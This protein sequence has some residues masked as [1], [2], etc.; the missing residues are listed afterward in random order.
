MQ[1]SMAVDDWGFPVGKAGLGLDDN[2][3]VSICMTRKVSVPWF[4]LKQRNN[5]SLIK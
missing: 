4:S 2:E 1:S 5:Y 3:K